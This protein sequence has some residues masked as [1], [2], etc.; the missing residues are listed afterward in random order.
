MTGY[1]AHMQALRESAR[2]GRS[3]SE[4]ASEVRLAEAFDG[5]GA[6]MPGSRSGSLLDR[7]GNALGNDIASWAT[8]TDSYAADLDA[9]ADRYSTNEDAAAADFS[10][11]AGA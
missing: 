8:R 7:T 10:V 5:A 11:Q 2:A 3:A 1:R 9:A 4:Q 6:A